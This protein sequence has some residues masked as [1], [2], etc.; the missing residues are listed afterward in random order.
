MAP[1][2]G[3]RADYIHCRK[4]MARKQTGTTKYAHT[5]THTV[6]QQAG[7][8]ETPWVT[9][10]AWCVARAHTEYNVECKYDDIGLKKGLR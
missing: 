8:E 1:W 9:V 4:A 3:R 6:A 5:H 10:D 2:Q 7:T